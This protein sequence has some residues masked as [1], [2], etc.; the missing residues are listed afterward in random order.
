MEEEQ[1][2]VYQ[3]D[4]ELREPQATETIAWWVPRHVAHRPLANDGRSS[5]LLV[6]LTPQVIQAEP[7]AFK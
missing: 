4:R 5:S 1:L 6:P 3:A 7:N 2:P